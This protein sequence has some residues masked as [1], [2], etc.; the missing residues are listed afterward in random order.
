MCES[1]NIVSSPSDISNVVDLDAVEE[2]TGLLAFDRD[3]NEDD[4]DD[5]N[6]FDD[7]QRH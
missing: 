6:A 3:D 4:G 2:P 5:Y 7:Y 1:A